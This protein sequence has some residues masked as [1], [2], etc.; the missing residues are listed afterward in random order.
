MRLRDAD[1]GERVFRIERN[2]LIVIF[3]TFSG[4]RQNQTRG[5]KASF[6]IKL[7]GFRVFRAASHQAFLRFAAEQVTVRNC[8]TNAPL[9]AFPAIATFTSGGTAMVSETSIPPSRKTPAHGVWSRVW[10]NFYR[11]KTKAF[12]FDANGNFTGWII[13]NQEVNLSRFTN[14]Y[15]S[16]GTA[17]IYA[18]NGVLVGGGCSTIAVARF[19]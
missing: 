12:N 11:F 6:H 4:F 19:E 5:V 14:E 18:P 17:E 3:Q 8:Q 2:R 7:V 15:E 10:G 9:A 13:I 1:I 16:T